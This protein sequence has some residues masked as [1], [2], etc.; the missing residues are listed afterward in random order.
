M[1]QNTYRPAKI[2]INL[3]AIKSNIS[4]LKQELN[5]G[6]DIIA[7]V[8]ANGYGHGAI[9]VAKSALEAGATSL[10][11]ALLEEAV[12]LRKAGIDVPILVLGWVDPAFVDVAIAHDLTLTVFQESWLD[13][14][15]EQ[16]P[17]SEKLSI[18]VKIDTGMGRIGLRTVDELNGFIDKLLR[19]DLKVTGV[20]THF[21]T[22]DEENTDYYHLQLRRL[23][24]MLD[25][26]KNRIQNDFIVH[27]G[28]SAAALRQISHLCDAVRFG[29]GMYGL[30]PSEHLKEH[31]PFNLQPALS[32]KTKLVHVKKISAGEAISYGTTYRAEKD[33]W[34]GTI[35]LGYGDGIL[36]R[37]QNQ[38]VLINGRRMRLVGRICMD[39][40]MV[41]LDQAYP[42]GTEVVFI[43]QQN[44]ESIQ[45][46]EIATHIGTIN[47]ELAC[48]LTARLPRYYHST[49]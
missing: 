21:A 1:N 44:E 37:W 10:A 31:R 30:Y 22:A 23:E 5:T 11:V 29:I 40:C 19:T 41:E 3:T 26:I 25:Q 14:Y 43:G 28:N 18:H 9:E 7:V 17:S 20:Y 35:P 45:L 33:Q 42:I 16:E 32:L 27:I 2:E 38:D 13:A 36:R 34:I 48:L 47:Y 46:E 12:E 49:D 39:Q 15:L 6:V 24:P 8:K 4:Q